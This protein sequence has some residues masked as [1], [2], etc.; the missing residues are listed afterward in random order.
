MVVSGA[1]SQGGAC[2][3]SR[4]NSRVAGKCRRSRHVC[5]PAFDVT[6]QRWALKK[7]DF[8]DSR[9]SL[10]KGTLSRHRGGIDSC[11]RDLK[12][13]SC[14]VC[15]GYRQVAI[16]LAIT[17]GRDRLWRRDRISMVR[18]SGKVFVRRHLRPRMPTSGSIRSMGSHGPMRMCSRIRAFHR[19]GRCETQ[20][21]FSSRGRCKQ[22]NQNA[23]EESDQFNK[24]Q[25]HDD[26]ASK[27]DKVTN[28]TTNSTQHL[29]APKF[30]DSILKFDCKSVHILAVSCL[31]YV[32]CCA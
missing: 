14:S 13:P 32:I 21:S 5:G 27:P 22:Y 4:S 20:R 18:G 19:R 30:S 10:R 1:Q 6:H 23:A 29:P 25:R 3:P 15:L 8:E 9:E 17:A 16:W 2:H 26:T 11:S 31:I 7:N 28:D 24:L 12:V